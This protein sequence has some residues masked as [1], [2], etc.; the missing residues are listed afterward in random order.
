[1]LLHKNTKMVNKMSAITTQLSLP[2]Y[3]RHFTVEEGAQQRQKEETVGSTVLNQVQTRKMWICIWHSS[4]TK[5]QM[6]SGA[7]MSVSLSAS[8]S[9]SV[10]LEMKWERRNEHLINVF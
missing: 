7:S 10:K 6:S 5:C 2:S 4:T 9:S 8:V 3:S 1:M